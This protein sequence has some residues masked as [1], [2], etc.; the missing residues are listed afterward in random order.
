MKAL[1]LLAQWPQVTPRI[2]MFSGHTLMGALAFESNEGQARA[3]KSSDR[4]LIAVLRSSK[5]SSTHKLV[6]VKLLRSVRY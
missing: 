6:D 3:V 5:P 1:P 4:T 2:I